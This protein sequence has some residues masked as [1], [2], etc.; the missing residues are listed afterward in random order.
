MTKD[1]LVETVPGP[2][3]E[4]EVDAVVVKEKRS[5]LVGLG[6]VG[7]VHGRTSNAGNQEERAEV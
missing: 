7:G 3:P 2:D 1:V 6:D 5:A 4:E